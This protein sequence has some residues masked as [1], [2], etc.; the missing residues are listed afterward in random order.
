VDYSAT[1]QLDDENESTRQ[2]EDD[3]DNESLVETGR[4]SSTILLASK[5]VTLIVKW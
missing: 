5:D 2:L 1:Q 3:D 4:R